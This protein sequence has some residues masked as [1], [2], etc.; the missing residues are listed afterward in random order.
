MFL[1][2]PTER[3]R[4]RTDH[5]LL[6]LD[7][8]VPKQRRRK[9]DTGLAPADLSLD[10]HQ[11]ATSQE[12]DIAIEEEEKRKNDGDGLEDYWKDFALA[13]ESTKV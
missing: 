5:S 2:L 11:T 7:S 3:K 8:F 1:S 12:P 4:R 9:G 6:M 10:L 13:V